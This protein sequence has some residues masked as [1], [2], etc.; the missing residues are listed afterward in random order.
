MKKSMEYSVRHCMKASFDHRRFRANQYFTIRTVPS[1]FELNIS[2]VD[3]CTTEFK[4]VG[5]ALYR[6]EKDESRCPK[7]ST[8]F[9]LCACI[10]KSCS[11]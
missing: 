9:R 3:Q 6:Q 2:H 1:L 4:R 5:L 11:R 7:V 10:R 8:V